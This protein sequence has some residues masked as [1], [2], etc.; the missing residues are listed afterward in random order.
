MNRP[1]VE[2]RNLIVAIIT[3][4]IQLDVSLVKINIQGLKVFSLYNVLEIDVR[5]LHVSVDIDSMSNNKNAHSHQSTIV[6]DKY[7][8]TYVQILSFHD[9]AIL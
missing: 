3:P 9:K 7:T 5:K 1:D 4:A 8:T 2:L 6:M